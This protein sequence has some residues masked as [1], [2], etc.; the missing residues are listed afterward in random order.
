M[1]IARKRLKGIEGDRRRV[2]LKGEKGILFT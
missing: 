2:G 1:G